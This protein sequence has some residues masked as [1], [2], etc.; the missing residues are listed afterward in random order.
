M[1]KKAP[2]P[3]NKDQDD[4]KAP[5]KIVEQKAVSKV[6]QTE[7]V[8]S[9]KEVKKGNSPKKAGKDDIPD[10]KLGSIKNGTFDNNDYK[11]EFA[12]TSMD[13]PIKKIKPI[14]V[15]PTRSSIT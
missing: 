4:K 3:A 12:R 10:I 15:P 1:T 2:K 14:P 8:D 6:T 13:N 11:E 7:M 5:V 9:Q